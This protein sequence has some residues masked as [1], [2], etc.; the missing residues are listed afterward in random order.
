MLISVSLTLPEGGPR[1]AA[2]VLITRNDHEAYVL[3]I[4][5]IIGVLLLDIVLNLV[6][7]HKFRA[8]MI[9]NKLHFIRHQ[10]NH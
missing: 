10:R 8:L 5:V 9:V 6:D 1:L 4:Y 7:R 3:L 2:I